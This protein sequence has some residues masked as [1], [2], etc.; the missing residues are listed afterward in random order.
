[1]RF[2]ELVRTGTVAGGDIELR[3]ELWWSRRPVHSVI[4]DPRLPEW[5]II[6]STWVAKKYRAAVTWTA[7]NS[8]L[9]VESYVELR[10]EA[11]W[12]FSQC[13]DDMLWEHRSIDGGR[14]RVHLVGGEKLDP[15]TIFNLQQ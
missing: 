9:R 7:D 1:M 3:G 15:A 2:D 8:L 13:G 14:W 10:V 4:P 12:D 5:F 6:R 11:D